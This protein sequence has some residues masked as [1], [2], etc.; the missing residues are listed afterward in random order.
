MLQQQSF[1]QNPPAYTIL[2]FD[3]K[4]DARLSGDLENPQDSK[5]TLKSNDWIEKSLEQTHRPLEESSSTTS[6]STGSTTGNTAQAPSRAYSI[7]IIIT[8]S[9][10]VILSLVGQDKSTS[11]ILYLLG[12]LVLLTVGLLLFAGRILRYLSPQTFQGQ[13]VLPPLRLYAAFVQFEL[14]MMIIPTVCLFQKVVESETTY[15]VALG[16]LVFLIFGA[17]IGIPVM[18]YKTTQS[19][20]RGET[21]HIWF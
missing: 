8:C 1:D 15:R 21:W 17:M 14:H 10:Y 9:I 13:S 6:S 2:S 11:T 7:F 3:E 16:L 12:I 5:T 19:E 4:I 20:K 18:I